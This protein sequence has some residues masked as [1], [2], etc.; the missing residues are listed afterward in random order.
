LVQRREEDVYWWREGMAKIEQKDCE[1]K[2]HSEE[3][4]VR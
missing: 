2:F 1:E 3:K 4:L